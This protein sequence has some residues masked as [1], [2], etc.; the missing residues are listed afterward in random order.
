VITHTLYTFDSRAAFAAAIV[1]VSGQW[2]KA[3]TRL[4]PSLSARLGLNR[5]FGQLRTR[6]ARRSSEGLMTRRVRV[7][8]DY[9]TGTFGYVWMQNFAPRTV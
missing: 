3:E 8:A 2:D 4:N 7:P 5:A 1:A 6:R 9:I